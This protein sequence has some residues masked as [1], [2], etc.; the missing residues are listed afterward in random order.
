VDAGTE[1]VVLHPLYD[2]AEQMER[3]VAEVVPLVGAR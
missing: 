2:D 1:L 3:L